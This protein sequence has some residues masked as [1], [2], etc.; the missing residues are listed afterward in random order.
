MRTR[1]ILFRIAADST[2]FTADEL[3][4][5]LNLTAFGAAMEWEFIQPGPGFVTDGSRKRQ[6]LVRVRT[7]TERWR[8]GL[9]FE[10]TAL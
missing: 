2:P 3:Y 1:G 6:F 10:D 8:P 5:V 4:V 7:V 9:V